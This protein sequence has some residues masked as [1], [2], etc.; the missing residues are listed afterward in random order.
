MADN[1]DKRMTEGIKLARIG[2]YSYL[3]D[4]TIINADQ[5]TFD[6]FELEGIY[7][8][9]ESLS[10]QKIE[11][12]FEYTGPKGRLREELRE[13]KSVSRFEYGIKTLKGNEKWGMHNSYLF[14]DEKTGKEAVQV[15][16]YDIT[17]RK[18]HEE[19]KLHLERRIQHS[20]KLR[21]IGHLAG[22]VAHDFN[23]QLAGII[24][25]ADLLRFELQ[26]NARLTR[27]A[28]NILTAARHSAEITNQLLAFA[29]KGKYVT[30]K[31]D[32][33]H[34]I[35]E[36]ISI[37]SHSIDKRIRLLQ[38][39]TAQIPT[40]EGDPSQI[41]NALL[42]LAINSRDAMP[43]GGVITFKTD[44]VELDDR[45]CKECE[46]I[47]PGKYIEIS[48]NDT[49]TGMTEEVQ[50]RLFEPFFTTKELGKG[51]GMGLAAVYGTVK[52]H[53]GAIKVTSIP[54]KGTTFKLYLPA[55]SGSP[56]QRST[57]MPDI[58]GTVKDL[59]VLL[60]DDE[61]I[62]CRLG[63]EILNRGGHKVTCC[64]NGREAVDLYAKNKNEFDLVILDMMMPEMNGKDTFYA[65]KE[66]DP[67][68]KVLF[69]SGF[70]KN[71]EVEELIRN[72]AKGFLQKPFSIEEIN[73]AISDVFN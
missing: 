64:S 68:I 38:V 73:K 27:Y 57:G 28:E 35:N 49:G 12:L 44:N 71:G 37:L 16:F 30:E 26:E 8:D 29:R 61:M 17:E 48:I 9:H 32:I 23:N 31:T 24:G 36:V 5:E 69:S 66:I 46:E 51:T 22:G 42:N 1:I 60:V 33:H 52:Y 63:K 55:V 3:F 34:I 11:S 72:G 45:F 19:E 43:D 10:G 62:I 21:A 41:H 40:V 67:D 18:K 6:F 54:G 47:T 4:G 59:S 39:L 70:S 50:S 7:K 2:F 14:I 20:E 53:K 58:N 13:N 65:L 15:C 56:A 25:F